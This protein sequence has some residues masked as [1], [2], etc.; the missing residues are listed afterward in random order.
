MARYNA[1]ERSIQ[2]SA[3]LRSAGVM[4]ARSPGGSGRD[5]FGAGGGRA[6]RIH[7]AA[8]SVSISSA[9]KHALQP[10]AALGLGSMD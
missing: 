9:R 8:L 3:P 10:T 2:N 7:K 6:I 1:P 5:E 4:R